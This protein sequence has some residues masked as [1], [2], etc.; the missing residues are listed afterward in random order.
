MNKICIN[1][2]SCGNQL[3]GGYNK[4]KKKKFTGYMKTGPRQQPVQGVYE[5]TTLPSGT[6][7]ATF[8]LRGEKTANF[9]KVLVEYEKGT[10]KT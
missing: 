9:A 5:I 8:V 6:S 7:K 1:T 3:P 2:S 4:D 10:Y